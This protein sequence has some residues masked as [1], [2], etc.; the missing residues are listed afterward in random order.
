MRSSR[1]G[2]IAPNER[3]VAL[4]SAVATLLGALFICLSP[5][6]EHHISALAADDVMPA[7][8]CPYENGAC[9]LQPTV[10]AAVLTSPPPEGPIDA[11]EQGVR[12]DQQP[13][14]GRPAGSEALARA[15]NLHVLQVLRT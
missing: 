14:A 5:P 6:A 9:G 10:N 8:S 13:G 11:E 3:P 15:P 2:L 7:F 1:H 12:Y 4:L